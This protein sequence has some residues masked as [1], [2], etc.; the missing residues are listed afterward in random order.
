MET[1]SLASISLPIPKYQHHLQASLPFNMP[2]A[3]HWPGIC[4]QMQS[5]IA[6]PQRLAELTQYAYMQSIAESGELSDAQLETVVYANMRFQNQVEDGTTFP[7]L[8]VL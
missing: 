3:K 2:H 8:P 4:L 1:A 6:F 7:S 5:A